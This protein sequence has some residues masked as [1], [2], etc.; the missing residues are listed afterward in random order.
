[1][2]YNVDFIAYYMANLQYGCDTVK[3]VTIIDPL[4]E[5]WVYLSTIALQHQQAVRQKFQRL[6]LTGRK[7]SN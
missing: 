3:V 6:S 2:G 7:P 5:S 1:M 4:A